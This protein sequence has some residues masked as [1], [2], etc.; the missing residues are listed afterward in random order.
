[1]QRLHRHFDSCVQTRRVHLAKLHF[2]H[3]G[4]TGQFLTKYLYKRS[5]I[6]VNVGDL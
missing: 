3:S 6:L 5:G 4:V 2:T 1:M